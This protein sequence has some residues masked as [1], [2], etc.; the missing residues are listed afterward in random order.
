MEGINTMKQTNLTKLVQG[1]METAFAGSE[2][3]EKYRKQI[4]EYTAKA[5]EPFIDAIIADE[6]ESK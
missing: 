3:N 6:C 2:G 5:L 1:L 4:A